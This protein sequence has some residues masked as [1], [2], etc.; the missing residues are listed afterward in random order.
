M[1]KITRMQELLEILRKEN[2]AYYLY[3]NPVVT[4]REYDAQLDELAVLEKELGIVFTNSPTQKVSGDV[5]DSLPKVIHTKPML[6]AAKTKSHVDIETFA[7]RAPDSRVVA[8]WKK[9]G[10]TL[11]LRYKDGRLSIA[12]TRGDGNVGEDVTHNVGAVL[13]IPARIPYKGNLEVRGECVISWADFNKINRRVPAPYSHPRNLAAGSIRLLDPKETRSRNLQFYAFELVAPFLDTVDR[14]YEFMAEQGFYVV[15]HVLTTADK[16]ASVIKSE[17]F[18]PEKYPIPVDGIIVEYNDKLFGQSLGATGHH[19]NCR[20]AYKW[21][22]ETYKTKFTGIRIQ[23]TRTGIL[24]LTAVFKPVQIEGAMVQKATLHNVDFFERLKLGIGD[25]IEVYKANKII[26]AIAMNNTKSGTYQLP[27]TCPCCGGKA[28][29]ETR[30]DT[31]YLVC[32]NDACPAK[33]VRKFEHFCARTYMEINGLSGATLEALI[34]AGCI[35]TYADIYHLDRFK[36]VIENLDGFGK[37]SYEKLQS[38]IESSRDDVA[39]SSFIASFG[40]PLV[41]RHIGK[42]LEK[43]FGTLEALLAAVDN[44]FDFTSIDG[45]GAQKSHNLVTWLKDKSN[46]QEML[47]VAQEVR[48]KAPISSPASDNPFNGKTVVATGSF[49]SFTR[50]SINKKLEELGAKAGSSVSKKT[51]YV[52]AGEKAGSKLTKAQ[53]LGIK[54]LTEDEFLSMI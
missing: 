14:T 36:D 27:D 50:D 52:I 49:N 7:K 24:S 35:K 22:D 37:R 6:S 23:P 9:D 51:D 46:R 21:Q 13:G 47:A 40:I 18:N 12:I 16:V 48:F 11:V 26:P 4:D 19:E 45:L 53:E 33:T 54:V 20:I 41:G 42:I 3:D 31:R 29:V 30:V 44:N 38:A 1:D 15:P 43:K 28:V 8:S 39:L 17:D 10:L 32:L 2:E 25:E 5:L 34:D